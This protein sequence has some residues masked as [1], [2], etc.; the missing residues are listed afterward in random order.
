MAVRRRFLIVALVLVAG[1]LTAG[2]LMLSRGFS[3]R[4]EPNGV[5][6][7]I[8]TRLR[9]LAIPRQAR[10]TRNPVEKTDEVMAEA[11]AHFADHCASC[12]ANDGSGATPLGLGLYPPPPDMRAEGTQRLT[13]GELFYVIHNGIRFTG[14]PAFG[15]PDIEKDLD[16]WNLVH[17]IR[18]L[19][20]ISDDELMLMKDMNPRS[21]RQIQMEQEMKKFLEG[22]APPN[23]H[24]IHR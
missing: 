9:R 11:M 16:S 21:P 1:A 23:P 18:H 8:A 12:H 22:G 5:E 20:S 2:W 19:P 6:E 7:F 10:E 13:D 15:D 4:D 14:M 3:A 24:A 17:F